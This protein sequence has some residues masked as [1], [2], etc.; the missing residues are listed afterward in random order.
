MKTYS[1]LQKFVFGVLAFTIVF[2]CALGLAAQSII[3][4]GTNAYVV[5]VNAAVCGHIYPPYN[6]PP[7]CA[8]NFQP[9]IW[10]LTPLNPSIDSNAV[11]TAWNYYGSGSWWTTQVDIE[12][13]E[14]GTVLADK[15]AAA[16]YYYA[17]PQ[18][19]FYDDPSN[20]PINFVILTATQ[21]AF[22]CADSFN[23]DNTGGVSV[24]IE[25]ISQNPTLTIVPAASNS[26]VVSWPS[27]SPGFILQQNTV[28]TTLD[29]T[30]YTGQI[31]NDGT[32]YFTSAIPAV[33]NMFF[34]LV[35]QQ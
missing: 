7:V 2:A 28:L 31:S 29:W 9:G 10:R 19:A 11:Y 8:L 14:T 25:L 4:V 34:R 18:S 27:S 1:V 23:G 20:H 15:P 16:P 17:D 26:V 3:N 6:Y 24:R 5:N 32:N 22:V 21:G 30:N 12:Q 33:G 35:F 13:V